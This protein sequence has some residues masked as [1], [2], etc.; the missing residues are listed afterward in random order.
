MPY[1]QMV[2][3]FPICARI[4]SKMDRLDAMRL[5]LRIVELKSLSAA[6]RELR[7]KQST[8]SKWLA[9]LEEELGASLIER[10][11]R[12]KRV[13]ESGAL[14]YARAK[15]LLAA[16]ESTAAEL[17]SRAPEPVGRLRVS[18]PVV[19]GRM[20]VAPVACEFLRRSPKVEID[21]VFDDR[22]VNLVEEGFDVAVRVGVP[23][24]TS[25]RARSLGGTKRLLVASPSYVKT[26][27]APRSPAE[28]RRHACLLH[29]ELSAG[30]IWIFRKG[31]KEH[32]AR[33]R[34]RFAANN[35]EAL[36][37]AA[38]SGLGIALLAAWLVA[39]DVRRKR[40]VEL[41]PAYETPAAP[42]HLLMPPGRHVHPR[43]RAFV[44][45]LAERLAPSF[46][47]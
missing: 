36:R 6:A 43:V 35:S 23:A 25:F 13:T 45:F 15:E 8:A 28:L 41:L 46:S 12:T 21:L 14:F 3:I 31:A 18:A 27:G 34:G 10:T 9:A 37:Q 5:Y 17:S 40:L 4:Y 26:H 29:S 32:R 33:V 42:I 7:V 39:D 1:S 20:F 2:F 24:D 44:D 22:Y 30:T 11:T 38:K 16:Y 47:P 19:F